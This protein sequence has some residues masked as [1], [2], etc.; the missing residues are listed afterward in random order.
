MD[1]LCS[2]KMLF[3]NP[4]TNS[5]ELLTPYMNKGSLKKYLNDDKSEIQNEIKYNSAIRFCLQASS[6][7][8][9]LASKKIIHRDLAARNCLLESNKK[10]YINLRICDFGLAKITQTYAGIYE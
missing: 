9:Y 10:D 8:E 3:Q 7:M 2:D 6:G 5:P 4:T 1:F